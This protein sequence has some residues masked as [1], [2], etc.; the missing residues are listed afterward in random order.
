MLQLATI[1][2]A[3]LDLRHSLSTALPMNTNYILRRYSKNVNRFAQFWLRKFTFGFNGIKYS[4]DA[5]IKYQA[6]TCDSTL[7]RFL[8]FYKFYLPIRTDPCILMPSLQSPDMQIKVYHFLFC[9]DKLRKM[10][11]TYFPSFFIGKQHFFNT[12]SPSNPNKILC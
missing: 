8:F 10:L 2:Q 6:T 12:I 4:H 1:L 9:N 7:L 11:S 3:L 5:L